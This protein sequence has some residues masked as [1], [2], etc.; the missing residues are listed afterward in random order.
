MDIGRAFG[1]VFDDERW[2]SKVLLGGLIFLIPIIGQIVV[3]GYMLQTAL[4]VAQGNPR[5]LPEWN[6]FVEHLTR[7]FYGFVIQLVYLLPGILL[8][9]VFIALIAVGGAAADRSESAGGAIGLGGLCL[10]PLIFLAFLLGSIAGYVGIARYLATGVLS[11]AFKFGDVLANLRANAGTWVMFVLIVFLAGI[12]A[13]LGLIACGVGVLFTLTYA[14][15]V[16]GHALGQAMR[17]TGLMPAA[18]TSGTFD[19]PPYNPPTF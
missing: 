16:N 4:N 12:A 2:V 6:T 11:E 10:F 13:Q 9:F 18:S 7:G 8:Y 17:A 1:F 5:P 14:Q 19:P 15:F 3:I